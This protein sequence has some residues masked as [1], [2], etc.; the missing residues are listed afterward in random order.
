MPVLCQISLC[1]SNIVI[2]SA[3]V[4]SDFSSVYVY[5]NGCGCVNVCAL[6]SVSTA[7][8]TAS[9]TATT[10]PAAVAD[11]TSSKLPAS[12]LEGAGSLVV[13]V[14]D[15][16]AGSS[17]ANQAE[18]FKEGRQFNA[19]QLQGGAG[20]GLGLFITQGVVDLHGGELVATSEGEGCGCTFTLTLPLVFAASETSTDCS[21]EEGRGGAADQGMRKEETAPSSSL[22]PS[23]VVKTVS[24][25]GTG[26]RTR[27][28]S[29][30]PPALPDIRHVLVVDDSHPS[31]KMLCRLLKNGG[32]QCVQAENGQECVD[33]MCRNREENQQLS[34]ARGDEVTDYDPDNDDD[35]NDNDNNLIQIVFMDFEM[36]VMKGNMGHY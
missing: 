17:L 32:Y 29:P 30:P 19:N 34:G 28:I 18:L 10:L 22:T 16:G 27:K 13:A 36:P 5:A 33:L 20:S 6:A 11:Y 31:R 35:D 3:I 15:S 4:F 26:M 21:V 23:S 14:T 2:H 24:G 12:S 8:W 25:A 9:A 7:V 1:R